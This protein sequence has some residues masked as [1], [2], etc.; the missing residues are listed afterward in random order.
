MLRRLSAPLALT[1]ALC[2]QGVPVDPVTPDSVAPLSPAE[3]AATF[4]LPE[5]Y[6]AELVAAE[7]LVV[8]PSMCV[9]DGDG[10]LWVTELRTYM[11]DIDGSGEAEPK[12]IVARLEDTDGDGRMDRRTE[13][14]T[15][16]VLPR[17]LLPLDEHRTLIEQTWDGVLWCYF[18][19]DG[20][21]VADRREEWFRYPRSNANLEHQDSALTFG[22]D[23]WLYTAMGGKRHRIGPDGFVASEDVPAEFAQWGLAVDDLGRQFFSSAGAER[24]AYD[25]QQHPL[26]GRLDVDG[27]L[28]D[29][30]TSVWP[31]LAIQDVQG[32]LARIRDDGTLDRFTGCCG[33]TI[34]RGDRLPLDLRGDYL[35]AEP[36]GRLIR[37]AKVERRGSERV[38]RNA[39]DHA[40]FLA[41][42]DPNFRPTW[43]ATGPDGCLW[44]VDMYRGIIQE[45]NWVRE[46]SYLR[47]VVKRFGLDANIGRGR[48]WR[49][50]HDDFA[51]GPNPHMRDA[52]SATLVTHLGHANGFWRDTAQRLL[53]LRG[54]HSVVPALR[55]MVRSGDAPLGRVHALWTLEGLDALDAATVS[56]ALRDRDARVRESAVRAS[57]SLLTHGNAALLDAVRALAHDPEVDVRLQVLRS[58]RRIGADG[59]AQVAFEMAIADSDDPVMRAVADATLHA[60]RPEDQPSLAGLSAAEVERFGAGRTLYR[61]LC[62]A[63]HGTDGHGTPANDETRLAPSLAG[64][65][66]LCSEAD[67]VVRILL[68]G[69]TGPVAGV[70]YPGNLMPPVGQNDDD[71]IAAVLTYARNAFGNQAG[72]IAPETV[73]AV[74]RATAERDQPFAPAEIDRFRHVTPRVAKTWRLTASDAHEPCANALDGDPKTRFSTGTAMHPGMWFQIDFGEPWLVDRI[75][76]D[77][78]GSPHDYPRGFAVLRSDDGAAWCDAVATGAG[79]GPVVDVTLAN[80]LASRFLRIVQTGTDETYWW[81]IH[82][83]LLFGRPAP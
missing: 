35:I 80:A 69:M 83:L 52:S 54:D 66:R 7:P 65:E 26:Y 14:A 46:G 3:E 28:A 8:E 39:Y 55:A 67:A 56:V 18:D 64:S 61:S 40:E 72:G 32:G 4:M 71:W 43:L 34:F 16:L 77:T 37:R 36:V 9:F 17:L 74:R 27:E 62:I 2:A 25:F 11:Q 29:G 12:G 48:I 6:H 70:E 24:P 23:N 45:G 21:G 73:A 22:I 20:D 81:S 33:Q 1:A 51:P 31:I 10:A 47:P 19:D 58:L 76:L 49:I 15:G 13:F 75:V 5:G 57:E 41:S 68:H 59:V 82:E 30:F 38:L 42:T 50:V 79:D 78:R 63:C 53:V 60:D 44:V